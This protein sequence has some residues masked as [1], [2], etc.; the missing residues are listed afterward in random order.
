[1]GALTKPADFFSILLERQSGVLCSPQPAP[2]KLRR[3][4]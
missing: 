3:G 4:P 2:V 1:M